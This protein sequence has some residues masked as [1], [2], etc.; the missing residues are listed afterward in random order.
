MG[1]GLASLALSSFA[2]AMPKNLHICAV[3]ATG[4]NITKKGNAD[5]DVFVFGPPLFGKVLKGQS[6]QTCWAC[7]AS[8]E[9]PADEISCGNRLRKDVA[10]GSAEDEVINAFPLLPFVR[11]SF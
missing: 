6:M 1:V 9:N 11:R 4:V 10:K 3:N 2:E 7:V 8:A 5:S